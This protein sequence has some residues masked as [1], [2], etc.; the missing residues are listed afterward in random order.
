MVTTVSKG[1]DVGGHAPPPALAE[2]QPCQTL[3]R[4]S[5]DQ[6]GAPVG[7]HRVWHTRVPAGSTTPCGVKACHHPASTTRA[8]SRTLA[9]SSSAQGCRAEVRG[10]CPLLLA[11]VAAWAWQVRGGCRACT[12]TAKEHQ[13]LSRLPYFLKK[14]RRRTGDEPTRDTSQ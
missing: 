4:R 11:T 1:G 3:L 5:T 12:R 6:G 9:L 8:G 7:A 2:P 13:P 10:G 14:P